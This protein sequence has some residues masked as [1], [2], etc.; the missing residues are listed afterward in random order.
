MRWG[1]SEKTMTG[2]RQQQLETLLNEAMGLKAEIE[3]WL[4]A[5]AG[6]SEKYRLNRELE[7][8]N[9]KIAGWQAEY[10]ALATNPA[11]LPP[12]YSLEEFELLKTGLAASHRQIQE[13]GTIIQGN[14]NVSGGVTH[15]GGT[16]GSIDYHD[17]RGSTYN[18]YYYGSSTNPLPPLPPYNPQLRPASNFYVPLERKTE[19][20]QE[21]PGEFER[22]EKLLEAAKTPARLGL[23]GVTGM[24]GIG[25]TQLA[26]E[27]AHRLNDQAKFP[28]GIYWLVATGPLNEW[29]ARL[30]ALAETVEY[31]PLGDD[32][33]HPEN[34]QRRA[35]Y[36]ARYLAHT[37][38][39]LLLLDNVD[40]PALVPKFLRELTGEEARCALL[41][42][43]RD[44]SA[45]P[46]VRLYQVERLPPDAALSLLLETTRPELLAPAI[47]HDAAPEAEAAR[48]LCQ[49][50]GYLPLALTHLRAELARNPRLAV[51]RLLDQLRVQGASLLENRGEAEEAKLFATFEISYAQ[52]KTD[53]ARDL[54]LA[55]CCFQQ[56]ALLPLWLLGVA[57]GLGQSAAPYEPLADSLA[58]LQ[59]LNLLDELA[60]DFTR[61]HP[62]VAQFGVERLA[63]FAELPANAAG[64]I[65]NAFDELLADALPSNLA[66]LEEL[67]WWQQP[68]TEREQWFNKVLAQVGN[69]PSLA[70]AAARAAFDMAYALLETKDLPTAVVIYNR[71]LELDPTFAQA[72]TNRG[73]AYANLKQY[74]GAIADFDQA[75]TLNPD[76]AQAFYNRAA[77]Y[78]NMGNLAAARRDFGRAM[79]LGDP[80]AEECL[81]ALDNPLKKPWWQKL[82]R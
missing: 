31:R 15:T 29:N 17:E 30:A 78:E 21:R 32:P 35:R 59:Q 8:V 23:V 61:L 68:L 81:K 54:F 25:K 71:V 76:Y 44:K 49:W 6:P 36:L 62:L 34:A 50:A 40:N 70:K 51:A 67:R 52:I 13:I 20:F 28:G 41:Y 9:A 37:S 38:D 73:N 65:A 11:P 26:V 46:G 16:V 45:P 47:E 42:T 48:Q 2:Q 64:R 27:L 39:A 57:A 14:L 22:L 3:R 55:A 63:A 33:G 12:P 7:A 53:R 56:A 75:I 77:T 79:A 80:Y 43:S 58:E 82:F 10:N 72:F 24:G 60:G 4:L 1:G 74:V 66:G 19:L 5:P 18:N 69:R